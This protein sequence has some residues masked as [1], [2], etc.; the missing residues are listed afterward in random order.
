MRHVYTKR[1]GVWV[2]GNDYPGIRI[3]LA[4]TTI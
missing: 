3:C 2:L 4:F 1:G